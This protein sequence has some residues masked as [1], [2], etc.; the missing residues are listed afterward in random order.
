M[1]GFALSIGAWQD[2]I[3]AAS[4]TTDPEAMADIPGS[5]PIL[6]ISGQEDP[7]HLD[8]T[9]TEQ[10]C[11]RYQQAGLQSV[12]TRYYPGARH[13]LLNE[14]NRQEVIEDLFAWIATAILSGR[15]QS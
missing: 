5:L 13:E 15:N 1:C 14:T 6:I 9:A 11:Q 4:I 7:A 8:C 2:I 3:E 10:I 12:E